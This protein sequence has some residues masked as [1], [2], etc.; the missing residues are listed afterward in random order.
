MLVPETITVGDLA[1][2]MSVKAAEVIKA[3]MKMG[4]MVTINQV[5]DQDTA[6]IVVEEMG[7]VAKR[8]KLDDPES[9]LTETPR[10]RDCHSWSRVRRS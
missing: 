4:T 6:M 9:F 7:H 1:Q 3:L 5:L 10:A 8:A 2:K